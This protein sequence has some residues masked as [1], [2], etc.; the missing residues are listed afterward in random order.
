MNKKISILILLV[1][2][3]AMGNAFAQETEKGIFDKGI[4]Y[5]GEGKYDEAIYEFTKAIKINPND[6]NIYINRG[7]AYGYKGNYDQAILD[8]TKAIE[9][10]INDA[11]AYCGRGLAYGHKGEYNEAITDFTKAIELALTMPMPMAIEG[12]PILTRVTMKRPS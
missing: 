8:Y 9:L 7:S 1:I 6:T 11:Q 5:I 12:P 4:K 2:F 3:I 10:N